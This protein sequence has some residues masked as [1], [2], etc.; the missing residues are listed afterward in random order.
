[1]SRTLSRLTGLAD[2]HAVAAVI[3]AVKLT[4]LAISWP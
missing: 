1:M 3:A 2:S 4:W